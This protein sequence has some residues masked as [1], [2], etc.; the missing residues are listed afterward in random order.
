MNN[1]KKPKD[2]V[3]ITVEYKGKDYGVTCYFS[4]FND[5]H[6]GTAALFRQGVVAL[7]KIMTEIDIPEAE[8][9]IKKHGIKINGK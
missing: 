1:S 2:N 7:E 5:K 6:A 9:A 3:K 4:S 8:A